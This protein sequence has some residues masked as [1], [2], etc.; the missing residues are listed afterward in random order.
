MLK[1]SSLRANGMFDADQEWVRKYRAALDNQPLPRLFRL[2]QLLRKVGQYLPS[3]RRRRLV[4]CVEPA[5]LKPVLPVPI[6]SPQDFPMAVAKA[7]QSA[8]AS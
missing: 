1:V 7:E 6:K 2:K 5:V 8:K 4:A 3:F